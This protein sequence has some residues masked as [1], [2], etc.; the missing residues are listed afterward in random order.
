MRPPR[1]WCAPGATGAVV[2]AEAERDGR[3]LL[4]EAEIVPGGRSRAQV[5]RQPLR[6]ARDLLG[7]LRVS[8]F[9][10][11]DLVIVK[12]GPGERRRFL[13][14]A[15]VALHP[16][17]DAVRSDVE[18][19]LRQ[20]NA[21]L[22]QSGGRVTPDIEATLD[23]WDA[24]LDD[25]GTA[26][27]AARD[28]LLERIR[29]ELGAA[30]HALAGKPAP[31]E[32]VYEPAWR[33]VGLGAALA[34]ARTDDLR[35]GVTTVGPHRDD[36]DLFLNDLPARTHASQGEQRSLALA[37][38]LAVHKVVTAVA[39]SAAGAAARRRVLR[40]RPR[41]QR[42]PAREPAARPGRPHHR[43]GAAHGHPPRGRGAGRGRRGA[44]RLTES[45]RSAPPRERVKGVG[46]GGCSVVARDSRPAAAHHR[47]GGTAGRALRRGGVHALP[48]GRHR[49]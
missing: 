32:A 26:L 39:E 3:E 46:R 21:L 9:S 20:R 37:L 41:P 47:R 22:K 15:L 29:P 1:P 19:V 8:V 49:P 24:K 17:N 25:A 34:A 38:R 33:S 6:R 40:A 18:R 35:R 36:L 30:Y 43:R 23:V 48:R 16:R 28:D 42:R 12:E 14:E 5:N 4:L 10:P 7:A 27:L 44:R 45:A 13:D 2:R 11:D 31:V